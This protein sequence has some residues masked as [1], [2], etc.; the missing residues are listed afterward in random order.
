M[1]RTHYPNRV[2][3]CHAGMGAAVGLVG[4]IDDRANVWQAA[5][6][7]RPTARL[8]PALIAGMRAAG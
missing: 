7:L 8:R 3:T 2:A 5:E 1:N 6:L 4:S